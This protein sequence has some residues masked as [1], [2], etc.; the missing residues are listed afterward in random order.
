[1][2]GAGPLAIDHFVKVVWRRDISRFHSYL[3]PRRQR[4]RGLI[5]A[6]ERY[7]AFLWFLNWIIGLSY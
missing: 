1:V 4:Q 5:F 2:C 6:C 7:G 3:V